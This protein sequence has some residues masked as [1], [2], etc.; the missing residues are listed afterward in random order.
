MMK[1][2]SEYFSVHVTEGE[3]PVFCYRSS[4]AV[5]EETLCNGVLVSSGWNAAGYPLNT[6]KNCPSRLNLNNYAQAGSFDIEL[7][8]CTV[9]FRLKFK[10]FSQEKNGEKLHTVLTLESGIMPVEIKV[11]TELD[12]TQMFARYIEIVN[13]GERAV[14]LS[15]LAVLSGGV[16]SMERD[17]FGARGDES[18]YYSVGY[19]D[20]YEWGREGDFCW[21][22]IKP[23]TLSVDFR[24]GRDRFRH[25]LIFIRNN[26]TGS[27]Y[28]SQIGWSG[29]CRYSVDYNVAGIARTHLSLSAEITSRSPITV[30]AA[31]ESFV[32]PKVHIGVVS[33]DLDCAVNEM[34]THVRKSVLCSPFADPSALIVG[35]GMGPEH[36]MSVETSKEYIDMFARMGAELFIVDAGWVCPPDEENRWGDYNGLNVPDAERYPNGIEEIA[37]YCHKKGMKFGLWADIENLGNLSDIYEK[38]PEWRACDVYGNSHPRL[39]D[40]SNPEAARWAEDELAR[41]IEEYKIDLLRVDHNVSYREYFGMRDTGTGTS[42]CVSI[43]H[44]NAV[45]AMYK[46]L[47]ERFPDVIFENCAGGG[48]RTDL[49]M[50]ENFNHTWVSDWQRA[51]R[52]AL[53]TNGMTMALPPERVDRLV[54]GMG[55]HEFGSLGF[56]MR[57]AMLGHLTLN[58]ISPNGMP[59][60]ES[61]LEFVRRS[62]DTYKNF[63]RKFLPDSKYY[64]HTPDCAECRESGLCILEAAANDKKAGALA[65]F[66]LSNGKNGRFTVYPKGVNAGLDYRVTLDNTGESFVASGAELMRKGVVL[67]IGQTLGSELVLYEASRE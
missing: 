48:G 62:V 15:K 65:V 13:K 28:F 30:I 61:Q 34:H 1:T 45:Y 17:M 38:H 60:N 40:M 52:S 4:L 14:N 39:I 58:V 25:P 41:I 67:E 53:I 24:F 32:S 23:D 22:D 8:G 43:R 36:D 49:G 56:H 64:H 20:S 59:I 31:G 11:H 46:R 47:K 66:T 3:N 6:L 54:S 35:A 7:D 44:I 9:N 26:L 21:H 12:G 37:D 2:D 16:E 33:G 50:M 63:I 57:N 42:E 51:P 29:G 18:K 19:F 10:G 27:L 5:Y 55:C